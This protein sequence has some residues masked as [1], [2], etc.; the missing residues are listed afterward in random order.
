[1]K[2]GRP[3][4]RWQSRDGKHVVRIFTRGPDCFYFIELSELT[5]EGRNLL[6]QHDNVGRIHFAG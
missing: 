5:E 1:M 3:G 2:V 4:E 6:D